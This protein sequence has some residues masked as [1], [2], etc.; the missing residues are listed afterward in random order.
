MRVASSDI[1]GAVEQTLEASQTFAGEPV[2]AGRRDRTR[3]RL[4]DRV[5]EA[6]KRLRTAVRRPRSLN[7]RRGRVAPARRFEPP[8]PGSRR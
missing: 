2:A 7:P 1:D 4:V 8:A 3:E 5:R 6:Q